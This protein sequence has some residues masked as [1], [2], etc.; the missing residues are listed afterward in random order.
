LESVNLA[1]V[2]DQLATRGADR[3]A[4][5]LCR[6]AVELYAFNNS[7][8]WPKV[9]QTG[10]GVAVRQ[11]DV[12]A[13]AWFHE[14]LGK[15]YTQTGAFDAAVAEHESALELRRWMHDDEGLTRSLN[16]IGLTRWRRGETELAEQ[17]FTAALESAR[18]HDIPAFEIF[19]L[20]NLGMV[21]LG[22]AE[23]AVRDES[24]IGYATA[25]AHL[26]QALTLLGSEEERRFYRVNILYDRAAALAGVGDLRAAITCATEAV[27]LAR[28]LANALLLASALLSLAHVERA[29]AHIE[30]AADALQESIRLFR[31]VGA[32]NR[33]DEAQRELDGLD[34][35]R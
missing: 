20:M 8:N 19:A 27:A 22:R 18:E 14:S 34:G 9:A 23:S 30:A 7:P 33:A 24:Q 5:E 32:V 25:L 31:S 6:A 35:A 26:D 21:E 13:Q 29:T 4:I 16:A 2:A 12:D 10:L 15:L 28:S 11:Q 17:S 3:I 1:L